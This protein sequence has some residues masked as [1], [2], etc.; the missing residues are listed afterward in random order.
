VGG[1]KGTK[2]KKA[3]EID[4]LEL[5]LGREGSLS[6]A[7]RRGAKALCRRA[8]EMITRFYA[9]VSAIGYLLHV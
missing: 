2:E 7:R 8:P 9:S 6:G 4:D 1:K 5:S 3:K